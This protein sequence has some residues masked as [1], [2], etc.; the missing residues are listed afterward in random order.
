MAN[1]LRFNLALGRDPRTPIL[2]TSISTTS[3]DAGTEGAAYSF[4][5]VGVNV[6]P[7][8]WSLQSGTL[9]T[10]VTLSA[11]GLLSGT[12]TQ[13]GTFG[14]LVFRATGPDGY[15][16]KTLSLTLAAAGMPTTNL[17]ALYF[18]QD[19]ADFTFSSG[20]NIATWKEHNGR[21]AGDLDFA[22]V[23]DTRAVKTAT[24]PVNTSQETVDTNNQAGDYQTPAGGT[25]ADF[26][27]SG[28]GTI[29]GKVY[30]DSHVDAFNAE[31]RIF[32]AGTNLRF[33][34]IDGVDGKFRV[35]TNS[36]AQSIESVDLAVDTWYTF[37]I[38]LGNGANQLKLK[39]NA[40]TEVT[41]TGATISTL[42]DR[43]KLFYSTGDAGR[44]DGAVAMFAFYSDVHDD[45]TVATNMALVD[46]LV[47]T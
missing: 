29:Y 16:E 36:A 9:P 18:G 8:G 10:G 40:L 46:T 43:P 35:Q 33:G 2:V 6:S 39:I 41:G 28:V 31:D 44:F 34:F 25:L 11:S 38:R 7:N 1:D 15:V 20:D 23:S 32:Y 45:A 21:G 17:T 27:P 47:A 26:L 22:F 12:P 5:L 37:C 3:L 19:D 4:Q 13:S 14:S 42:T 24:H 30:F